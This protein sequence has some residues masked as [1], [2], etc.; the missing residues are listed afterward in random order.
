MKKN[1]FETK[2]GKNGDEIED[3]LLKMKRSDITADPLEI[4]ILSYDG[5]DQRGS[6]FRSFD[7]DTD[8]LDIVSRTYRLERSR[9]RTLN[10]GI[11]KSKYTDEDGSN[12]IWLAYGS[13]PDEII[14]GPRDSA[15][16]IREGRI[17]SRF[18][19]DICKYLKIGD[20]SCDFCSPARDVYLATEFNE[21][22]RNDRL[23]IFWIK[24]EQEGNVIRP[25]CAFKGSRHPDLLNMRN[26]SDG[27]MENK[28]IRFR[29][30]FDRAIDGAA[31]VIKEDAGPAYADDL[32]RHKEEIF[33]SLSDEYGHKNQN[34]K[35]RMMLIDPSQIYVMSYACFNGNDSH[36]FI[37][38][39]PWDIEVNTF[40]DVRENQNDSIVYIS[41]DIRE[42]IKE[43][44]ASSE[45]LIAFRKNGKTCLLSPGAGFINDFC[46]RLGTGKISDTK[47]HAKFAYMASLLGFADQDIRFSVI[48]KNRND[49]YVFYHAVKTLS[50][51]TKNN[52]AMLDVYRKVKERMEKEGL[53]VESWRIDNNADITV[54]FVLCDD[55]G[56]PVQITDKGIR[57]GAE[58]Q[59]SE[60][61]GYAYR[62]CGVFYYMDSVFY[63]GS[64]SGGRGSS[65]YGYLAIYGKRKTNNQNLADA[66]LEGFF[67]GVERGA[68]GRE[69]MRTPSVYRYLEEQAGILRGSDR[70]PYIGK[71][72][73]KDF[74]GSV[75]DMLS[76]IPVK[77]IGKALM[78][79]TR[80]DYEPDC[81]IGKKIG[82]KRIQ[83]AAGMY[84]RRKGT[85]LDV[86]LAVAAIVKKNDSINLRHGSMDAVGTYIAKYGFRKNA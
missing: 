14:F 78:L 16:N 59:M 71:R 24:N 22:A 57:I 50:L 9:Y 28:R 76:K 4:K 1:I 75:F 54:N 27:T 68:D 3:E 82:K 60:G 58:L 49:R 15:G 74:T 39:D 44:I 8:S 37:L 13:G 61:L 34:G 79:F 66:L 11:I 6:R 67:S 25:L 18:I 35:V 31:A 86:I 77:D 55:I 40:S 36:S 51:S 19:S 30:L 48:Q 42:S 5:E 47:G 10:S 80:N 73:R 85:A 46:H 20:I 69:I 33:E 81:Q 26:P 7:A 83:E 23:F 32:I 64:V 53:F 56:E 62:L 70:S 84:S 43:S 52:I 65:P 2:F 41:G 29:K 63:C 17:P 72:M 12:G 21:F 45:F 38:L